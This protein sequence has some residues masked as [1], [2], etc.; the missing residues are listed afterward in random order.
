MTLRLIDRRA[1]ICSGR[2]ARATT[3]TMLL[4]LEQEGRSES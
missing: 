4:P 3:A 1:A 2:K